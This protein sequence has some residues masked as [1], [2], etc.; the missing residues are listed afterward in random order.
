MRARRGTERTPAGA[1]REENDQT[2]PS[3]TVEPQS[4]SIEVHGDPPA[5]PDRTSKCEIDRAM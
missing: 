1:P 5:V 3:G 2:P 4:G